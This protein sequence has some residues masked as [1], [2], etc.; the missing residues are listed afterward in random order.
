MAREF[1]RSHRIGEMLMRE[2]ALIIQHDISDPRVGMV[3]VSHVDVTADLKH[4]KVYVTHLNKSELAEHDMKECLA[5]LARASGFLRRGLARRV[6]LRAIPEL[7]FYY[8]KT[9]PTKIYE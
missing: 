3:T 7:R 8:D 5:G 1:S 4:A 6:E 9:L 2:L